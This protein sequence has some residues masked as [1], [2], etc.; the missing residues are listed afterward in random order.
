MCRGA[1]PRL[2]ATAPAAISRPWHHQHDPVGVCRLPGGSDQPQA[3][4][5]PVNDGERL[6]SLQMALKC[7]DLVSNSCCAL[8]R[9][10]LH[11]VVRC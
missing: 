1:G 8:F 4:L 9:C 3:P 6:L 5:Q 11:G 10:I 7:A 2:S